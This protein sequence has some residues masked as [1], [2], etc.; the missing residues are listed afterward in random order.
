MNYYNEIDPKA[1]AWLRALIKRGLIPTGNV[2][3]RSIIDVKP[4]DIEGCDQCHFFAGIAGWSIALRLAGWPSERQVWTASCP[5]QPLSCA[6][7]GKGHADERHLWPA[8]YRLVAERKP[9]TIIGEQVSSK[10]GREW[11]SGVRADLEGMGYA[12]GGADLCSAGV[13]APNIRQRL[14][15][16]AESQ[17]IEHDRSGN[18]RGRRREST[19]GS[20]NG[21]LAD[22]DGGQSSDGELQR[23]GRHLQQPQD[24]TAVRMGSPIRTGLEG[25][26]GNGDK[27]NESGRDREASP[28]STA[29]TGD[30]GG[31]VHSNGT[32][33]Q[34]REQTGAP[35]GY[36]SSAESASSGM[37]ESEINGHERQLVRDNGE[38]TQRIEKTNFWSESVWHLCRDGKHRRIPVEPAFFP[39]AARLPGRVAMLRG[40]GNAINPEVAAQFIRAYLE[41]VTV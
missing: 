23:G 1:C 39:L 33:S 18:A 35:M 22:T 28:R 40:F 5:C 13:G 12:V 6:G 17:S 19:D 14:Y 11:F 24:E 30:V 25:H 37:G 32:G 21:R 10:D 2:D 15:W 3:E 26:A 36:G 41:I 16:V 7:L 8:F 31:M 29:E 38:S 27:G 20:D 4:G 9:A 34:P